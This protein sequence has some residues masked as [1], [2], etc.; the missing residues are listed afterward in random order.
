MALIDSYTGNVPNDYNINFTS[1]YKRGQW[2]TASAS[3]TVT[4]IE[5]R[6][7]K[8]SV[9]STPGTTTVSI[10]TVDGTNLPDTV[11]DSTTFDANAL[12][13]SYAWKSVTLSASISSG[14]KYCITVEPSA[15]G[16]V[17]AGDN[18]PPYDTGGCQIY[19][20]YWYTVDAVDML[21]KV[22]GDTGLA[23]PT[24]P[25]PANDSTAVDFSTLGLS[26]D[27]GG[28]AV[29][30]NVFIGASGNLTKVSNEQSNTT[31]TTSLTELGTIFGQS[32]INQK[33]YWRVDAS[34]GLNWVTGDEWNFDS[35]PI[36]VSNPTP[37][38]EAIDQS[39][40]VGASW[41][42]SLNT[43]KY[44]LYIA[45]HEESYILAATDLTEDEVEKIY[46]YY[47]LDHGVDYDWRIDA[48]NDFGVVQGDVWT[49]STLY[50]N[51][52]SAKWELI[53]GGSG[54]GP[55]DIPPGVPGVDF[56]WVGDNSMI[57]TKRLVIAAM[58]RIWFE[59]L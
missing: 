50:L 33:I 17:W 10:C 5:I 11:L 58:N 38:D 49:F 34:D 3:A 42:G 44:D 6:V 12:T 43:K 40:Y 57:T 4:S 31:Y 22:Y 25:S 14:T 8:F 59:D 30:Y 35:R 27:N 36:K 52:P 2:F 1:I 15:G 21:F 48:K 20:T 24:N 16:L 54:Q 28:G 45:P 13:T 23:K 47:Q 41:D 39:I 29:K 53:P 32:P 55:W 46:S 18:T 19:T 9:G 37:V 7:K 56:R 26:W 51:P